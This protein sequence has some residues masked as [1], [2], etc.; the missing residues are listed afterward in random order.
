MPVRRRRLRRNTVIPVPPNRFAGG[1]RLLAPEFP[2]LAIPIP[3]PPEEPSFV[4]DVTRGRDLVAL[5]AEFYGCEL[6]N[7]EDG[8]IVRP[9]PD[10]TARMAIR[11][12]YQHLG[13]RAIYE[14]PAPAPNPLDPDAPPPAGD[15]N[16]PTPPLDPNV[17][18]PNAR[19][20]PPLAVRRARTGRLVFALD[21]D[22]TL[23][24]SSDGILAAMGRLPML[25]HPLAT[26]KPAARPTLGPGPIVV[27]PGGISA[28]L[29]A[30]GVAVA[31][32]RAA[33]VRRTD[34]VAQFRNLAH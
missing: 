16:Q 5:S 8:P 26:P 11:F 9:L 25:V 19:P 24:F 27:L 33:D 15:P 13:E 22:E 34:A 30:D 6:F 2:E 32:A 3:P 10:A 14:T 1:W 12:P 21:D 23:E 29:A 18:P 28:T 20:E 31:K 7:G 17:D 4:V